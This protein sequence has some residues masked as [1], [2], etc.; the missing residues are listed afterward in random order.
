MKTFAIILLLFCVFINYKSIAQNKSETI[1]DSAT[2]EIC[3]GYGRFTTNTALIIETYSLTFPWGASLAAYDP[4]FY[5]VFYVGYQKQKTKRVKLSASVAYER[6]RLEN[7]SSDY[8]FIMN[9]Y[10]L[11]AGLKF[12]YNMPGAKVDFYGRMDI[13]A[14]IFAD[15]TNGAD[16]TGSSITVDPSKFALQISPVC[17]RFGQKTGGFVELGFGSLGLFNFGMYHKF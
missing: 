8:S 12:R 5:G 13:G 15:K 4:H 9:Y 16:Q 11:L 14:L 6:I 7:L 17:I 1:A 10:T 3:F 2:S